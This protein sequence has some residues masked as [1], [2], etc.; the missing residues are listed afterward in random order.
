MRDVIEPVWFEIGKEIMVEKPKRII[1]VD[2]HALVRAGLRR[3]LAEDPGLEI[4]GEAGNGLLALSAV[5]LLAPHLVLMDLAMPEM[6]GLEATV[7]IKRRYP[8]VRVLI[9]T[10][11]KSAEYVQASVN[12]GADGYILKETEPEELFAA[13]R[14]VLQ[15]KTYISKEIS[16][17]TGTGTPGDGASLGA[18]SA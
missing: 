13:I 17:T 7:E 9:M 11:H 14:S 16:A 4:V 18:T 3:L 1:I 2:D 8:E 6:N 10:M 5:G 12:A 15:G